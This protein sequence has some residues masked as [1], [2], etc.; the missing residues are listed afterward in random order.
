[1]CHCTYVKMDHKYISKYLLLNTYINYKSNKGYVEEM[2][3]NLTNIQI[4]GYLF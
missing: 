1:M 3:G 2:P 4:V